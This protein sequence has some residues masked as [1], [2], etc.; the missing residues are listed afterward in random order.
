MSTPNNLKKNGEM[1]MQNTEFVGI[2]DF[3]TES[4]DKILTESILNTRKDISRH[5][6][7]LN[8]QNFKEQQKKHLEEIIKRDE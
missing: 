2:Q 8:E 4:F 5:K 3:K 7:M 6:L 1:A